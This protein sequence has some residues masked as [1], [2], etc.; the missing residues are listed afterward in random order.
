MGIQKQKEEEKAKSLTLREHL[1][2]LRR[3]LIIS[4]I[5]VVI[6]TAV[7]IIFAKRIYDFF[8]S[9]APDTVVFIFTEPGE[10]VGVY[11]KLCLYSG[12]V[13][14]L[15]VL[16]YQ[17]VKFV[18]PAL[19][20]TER[21]YLYILMPGVLLFFLGG[22]AFGYF[23]FL[24]PA[25]R[26]LLEF[27]FLEGPEPY[28][29][30][31]KYISVVTKLLFAMGLIFELPIV[32]YFLAR[33]GVVTPQGLSRYRRF[34]IVGAFVAAAIITPTFDPINQTIVAIPIIILYEI[35]ILFSRLAHIQRRSPLESQT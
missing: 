22:A 21:R 14:A 35:G 10:L 7:S 15:P 16:I 11:M 17:I 13:L 25:L 34:A 20:D 31:G 5:A 32:M 28:I 18:H 4:A 6:T 1:E 30:I 12:L 19:T 3:R 26:F 2:E 8:E 23:L 29:T 9:R 27:P 24:P 33:I